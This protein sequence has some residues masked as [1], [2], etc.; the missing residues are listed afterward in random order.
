MLKALQRAKSIV[1]SPETDALL[2]EARGRYIGAKTHLR[3]LE[4]RRS[5]L[6]QKL[7]QIGEQLEGFPEKRQLLEAARRAAIA[8]TARE[9]TDETKVCDLEL[10][11]E[12]LGLEESNLQERRRI[13]Q[14]DLARLVGINGGLEHARAA[15]GAPYQA[16]WEQVAATLAGQL[17]A[18]TGRELL[19]IW[20]A[21]NMAKPVSGGYLLEY[22]GAAQ[23]IDREHRE[24]AI[25]DLAKE[26]GVA[27][28]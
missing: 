4:E 24:K 10:Q 19:R 3:E 7:A 11:L 9:A 15:L 1:Q 5:A 25:R 26:F 16:L 13:F 12:K 14:E 28:Q 18:D 6:A 20:M 2:A 21:L 8:G 27:L 23:V 22:I 17:P